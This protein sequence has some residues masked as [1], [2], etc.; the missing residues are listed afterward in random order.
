MLSNP[1]MKEPVEGWVSNGSY[2]FPYKVLYIDEHTSVA[3]PVQEVKKYTSNVTVFTQ[4]GHSKQATIEVNQPLNIDNWKIYQFSYD[5]SM[6]KYSKTS[7]FELVRDPW[8]KVVYTGIFMLL[9]GSLF[10]FIVGPNKNKK[11]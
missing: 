11:S 7:V 10:L 8:I 2:V 6:G 5:E 1:E 9:A 4:N 3:M